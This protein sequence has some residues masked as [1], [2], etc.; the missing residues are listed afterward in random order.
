MIQGLVDAATD[1]MCRNEAWSSFWS[2]DEAAKLVR[3][4]IATIEVQGL[5]IVP[6]KPTPEIRDAIQI[7][8][9]IWPD[10]IPKPAPNYVEF[11]SAQEAEAIWDA[12]LAAAKI[13]Q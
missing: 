1:A 6:V 3:S 7:E 2:R 4:V 11:I 12:A 5:Q 8:V 9:D 13:A 10:S